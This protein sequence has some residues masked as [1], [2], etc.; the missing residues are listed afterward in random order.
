MR[1]VICDDHRLFSDALAIVLTA[2]DWTVVDCA[3][4]PAHA[5]AAVTSEQVDTCLMDLTF[6]D[7]DSGIDGIGSIHTASPDTKVVVLTGTSDPKLIMRAID[8]G[9]DGIAFKGDDIGHIVEVVERVQRGEVV[10]HHGPPKQPARASSPTTELGRFLTDRELELLEHLVRGESGTELARNM[11]IAYSTAR[12]HVQNVLTK[13]GVHTRLE[14]VAYA[15]A[16][17][18][19]AR[20]AADPGL[21]E[22]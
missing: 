19:V 15:I 4:D 1:V 16:H 21:S 13:L 5:L 8:S 7:G 20:P 11:G 6:P 14:A 22:L 17:G 18:L 10:M 3:V 2:H 12:T 9:A